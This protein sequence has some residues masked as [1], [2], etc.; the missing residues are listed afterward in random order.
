MTKLKKYFLKAL[1]ISDNKT[2]YFFLLQLRM[3]DFKNFRLLNETEIKI[4]LAA[5]NQISPSIAPF[6]EKKNFSLYILIPEN[7]NRHLVYLI[8][9]RLRELILSFQINV[10]ITSTGLYLGFISRN[11]FFLSLEGAEFF[12]KENIIPEHNILKVTNEGEKAILYGNP[13]TKRMI[14]NFPSDFQKS[15]I[16]LVLNES[17]ELIALARLE[18]DP[19]NYKLLNQGDLVATN[20]IDKGYYLRRKQ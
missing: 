2:T 13:I 16:L 15:A 6:I 18:N 3:R 4:I 11:T 9:E 8:F 1:L 14:S 12:L 10:K 19:S 5:L 17:R 20:L 7:E